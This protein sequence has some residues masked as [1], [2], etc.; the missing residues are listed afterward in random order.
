MITRIFLFFFVAKCRSLARRRMKKEKPQITQITQIKKVEVEEEVPF[1]QINVR[2]T[3]SSLSSHLLN[4][5]SS[6]F[7]CPFV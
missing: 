2:G 6:L 4:F 7:S 5:L 3:S 1:G